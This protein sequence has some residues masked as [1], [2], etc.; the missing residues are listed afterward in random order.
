MFQRLFVKYARS[1]SDETERKKL[2]Q[3]F[4]AK[5]ILSI[6]FYLFCVAVIFEGLLLSEEIKQQDPAFFLFGVTVFFWL[7]TAV[8]SLVLWLNF[9]TAYRKILNRVPSE[10]EMPEVVSYR[11]KTVEAK[12]G[13]LKAM[14]WAVAVFALGC[15]LLIA[16]VAIDVVQNSESEELG[17]MGIF[18]IAAFVI[19][20]LIFMLA[21]M[22]YQIRQSAKGQSLEL[23]TEKETQAIDEAQGRK[24]QYSLQ[25]DNNAQSFRY[26]FPD[27]KIK[28]RAESLRKKQINVLLISAMISCIVGLAVGFLFFSPLV[29]DRDLWGYL[30]PVC[31]TII[32]FGIFFTSLPFTRK[33][34]ALEKEQKKELESYSVY[35]KNLILYRKY[36]KFSKGKGNVI[37]IFMIGGIALS[38]VLAVLFPRSLYSMSGV[39]LLFAGAGLN[40]YFLTG[41]RKEAK[42][43]EEEIDRIHAQ[44]KFRFEKGEDP[45]LPAEGSGDNL[46]RQAD[47]AHSC[48]FTFGEAF[49]LGIDHQTKRTETLSVLRPQGKREGISLDLSNCVI[50]AL[51]LDDDLTYPQDYSEQLDFESEC[52]Y[53]RENKIL[54]MGERMEERTLYKILQNVYVQLSDEGFLKCVFLADLSLPEEEK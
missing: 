39:L 13:F 15:V 54:Q 20:F 22:F 6:V 35:E 19:C 12:R 46:S 16:G 28:K 14:W 34:S 1:V 31:M 3:L 21:F 49:S 43:I 32:F 23:L 33:Q 52:L 4:C 5:T 51:Y 53:D 30:F 36:E 11:Q 45:D 41:L 2:Y 24:Y 42:P 27:P 18:G 10:N 48:I 9:R 7:V 17:T 26:L 38:Y 40:Q 8:A 50:G 44:R 25:A 29:F 47:E 37:F